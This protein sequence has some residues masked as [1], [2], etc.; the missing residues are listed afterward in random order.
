MITIKHI[1]P[2]NYNPNAP[3]LY[4]Q[5]LTDYEILVRICKV[6]NDC[7]DKINSF[8]DIVNE[9]QSIIENLENELK[10]RILELL[11]Q[12]INDGT[13]RQM[14]TE[15]INNFS[16]AKVATPVWTHIGRHLF[17]NGTN[18]SRGRPL[19]GKQYKGGYV[20]YDNCQGACHFTYD[21]KRYFAANM[22]YAS[23]TNDTQ[24]KVLVW[25]E[26]SHNTIYWK[27]DIPSP[28][29]QSLTFNPA[30][31][32]LYLPQFTNSLNDE[33]NQ[34]FKCSLLNNTV[35]GKHISAP[36][37]PIH[38]KIPVRWW[39]VKSVYNSTTKKYELY[40]F[41]NYGNKNRR[42][43]VDVYKIDWNNS[44]STYVDTV[45]TPEQGLLDS[46]NGEDVF[47]DA[48]MCINESHIIMLS[49]RPS[50][51]YL[52]DR[53]I[54]IENINPERSPVW[55][56]SLSQIL[57]NAYLL[58][59]PEDIQIDNEFNVVMACIDSLGLFYEPSTVELTTAVRWFKT[60]LSRGDGATLGNGDNNDTTA[61]VE[62]ARY[63]TI[64]MHVD[65]SSDSFNPTGRST[66]PFMITQEAV[67]YILTSP[68]RNEGKIILD[69]D[70]TI[71]VF[72]TGGKPIT[73][74][75]KKVEINGVSTYCFQSGIYGSACNLLLRRIRIT[76]S[77]DASS[78]G[79]SNACVYIRNNGNIKITNN[80]YVNRNGYT[81]DYNVPY[82]IHC[83]YASGFIN[84]LKIPSTLSSKNYIADSDIRII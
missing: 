38:S 14:V 1:P 30:D 66:N 67:N 19:I 54:N 76:Q 79:N 12:W 36:A 2:I 47:I 50:R 56:Y 39:S 45:M 71:P 43:I 77:C 17:F 69:S 21:N 51:L 70:C 68:F 83:T 72:I 55:I 5:G 8:E 58:G 23:A 6:I 37:N 73:I 4:G 27:F 28:H 82:D 59:E 33:S 57:D 20:N 48:N 24:C 15:I 84:G 25:R 44:T 32:C 9:I 31:K 29:T 41:K 22:H 10:E 80:V 3:A 63:P 53:T 61:Q 60:S 40:G 11:K 7:I 35:E 13:L 62:W 78:F 46:S 64:T 65:Q 49:W 18:W 75:G 52:F 42:D 34:I 16:V 81:G 74:E 26:D